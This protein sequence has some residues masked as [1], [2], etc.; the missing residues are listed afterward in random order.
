M[1]LRSIHFSIKYLL[2]FSLLLVSISSFA[3]NL[4]QK[5]I[6]IS[7]HQR[8]LKE[9]LAQIENKANIYFSYNSDLLDEQKKLSIDVKD[10]P[11]ETILSDLL[12]PGY[13]F[14][15][16]GNHLIVKPA[17]GQ[18]II[19]SGKLIEAETGHPI[20]YASVY[21]RSLM[22]GTTTDVDGNFKLQIRQPLP[23]YELV[24]KKLSYEDTVLTLKK[25][26]SPT[27]P[28][29]LK[30]SVA[31][32]QEVTVHGVEQHW[33]AKQFI[34]TKDKF[35][36]INLRGY[37]AR[38]P[39]QFSL[40]PGLGSKD[41]LKGQT[42]NKFS[43][44]MIGGYTGGVRGFELGT[45]FNIVQRDMQYVQ[46]GGLFNIVGG[47]MQGVQ[48]GG[49]YNY[50][51]Q[52][53]RGVQFAGIYNNALQVNGVQASGAVSWTRSE[54]YGAQAAGL[55]NR[56]A[57]TDGVQFAGF[58]NWNER[59]LEG[60]QAAGAFNSN[61]SVQGI[62]CAGLFNYTKK[63]TEG[64]QIA[65]GL[66][67]TKKTMN[68]VQIAGLLNYAKT[69]N[70]TQLGLVNIAD[71]SSGLSLGLINII[72][73]GKHSIDL[74][75]MEWQPFN[76]SY[77]SGTDRLY[78]IF[79]VGGDPFQGRKLLSIGYGIG[80]SSPIAERWRSVNEI[81]VHTIHAGNWNDQHILGRYQLLLEYS[82]H[83]DLRLY[84]GPAL[85]LL[86]HE[87]TNTY[88]GFGVPFHT[89]YPSFEINQYLK[90]WIGWTLGISCF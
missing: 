6:S 37:F 76:L 45:G 62:Q 58:G 20:E 77:R 22:A 90:G 84:T 43:F 7:M 80:L 41:R 47:K 3:Q 55:I 36:S 51:N 61:D 83:P 1:S 4:L 48:V 88:D 86:Y 50:V 78:N 73:K 66:N 68:G 46:I 38:Q 70:G 13:K 71:S 39:Y 65:G 8:P 42:V 79:Q 26:Y 2:C 74:N 69:V 60:F 52:N 23:H 67:V 30:R 59:K 17:S 31:E 10:E 89:A 44:N 57:N 53:V 9:I 40:F 72:L 19:F 75:I 33:L 25:N 54:L 5:R 85:S 29:V 49:I 11:L 24:I 21:E 28:I 27:E 16:A 12:G 18:G 56:A 63:R 15:V 32:L 81:T 14:Q 82:F 64:A 34:S 87:N 35:N